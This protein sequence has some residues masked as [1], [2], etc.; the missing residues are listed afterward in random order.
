MIY[1][2][3]TNHVLAARR[4]TPNSVGRVKTRV[5]QVLQ[6][7][8]LLDVKLLDGKLLDGKLLDGKLLDVPLMCWRA[9]HVDLVH[10]RQ[11]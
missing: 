2:R 9:T 6:L 10:P 11:S 5:Q 3:I 7:L 4:N 8:G 1:T